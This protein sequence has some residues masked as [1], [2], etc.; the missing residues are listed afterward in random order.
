[1]IIKRILLAIVPRG[2]LVLGKNSFILGMEFGQMLSA[3]RMACV[4][5]DGN[6]IPWYTYP[7]IYFLR[8]LDF[9]TKRVFE[10]GSGNSTL[11]WSGVCRSLVSI[12][13]DQLWY[14]KIRPRLPAHVDYRLIQDK[15]DYVTAINGS[16][17]PYDVVIIDGSHRLECAIAAGSRVSENGMIVLDNSDWHKKTADYLRNLDLIEVDMNGFGP[18][19]HYTWTTSFFFTRDFRFPPLPQGQ[20]SPGIGGLR[21]PSAEAP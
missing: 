8:Q 2:I 21:H 13:D 1:M 10:Y 4:D 16:R 14:S 19:N 11:F 17:D 7:A 6:P 3:N 18:I 9:S 20:P 15:D 5:K 12:E